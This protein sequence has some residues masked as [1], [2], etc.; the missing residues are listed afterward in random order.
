ME[1]ERAMIGICIKQMGQSTKNYEGNELN[2]DQFE[3]NIGTANKVK[4]FNG[5][6]K[7]CNGNEKV[8]DFLAN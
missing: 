1:G 3:W 6:G 4:D 8:T 5:Y 2:E 7:I